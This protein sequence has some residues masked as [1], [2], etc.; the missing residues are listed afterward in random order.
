[1][2]TPFERFHARLLEKE[3]DVRARPVTYV[4][5]GDSVT[6]GC[7]E[8]ATIE[9][10]EVFPQLFKRMVEQRYPR[11]I[12]NVINSGVSADT[13]V[14]SEERWER[15]IF[16]Y[17]P[18]L[19]SIG[20]GV[21]DAH[22]GEAGLE[23]YLNGLKRLIQELRDRTSAEIVIL[24]PNMMIMQDN[25]QVHEKDRPAVAS[26]IRTYEAG[27][28]QR[29][30]EALRKL[31]GDENLPLVDVY[32]LFDEIKAQGQ[33]IHSHLVNGINHPSRAFHIRIAQGLKQTVLDTQG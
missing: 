15:D 3:E 19:I 24:T 5:F 12:M 33:D 14:R 2:M 11:T 30:T 31:A 21:N 26:F 7:M 13:V 29:Y 17:D 28:L 20:F 16:S 27:H 9:H 4:A 8:Y 1:M 10:Q 22:A 32:A 6:Q 23:A 25:P 18:D